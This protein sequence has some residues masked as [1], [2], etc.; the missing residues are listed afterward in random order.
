MAERGPSA[1]YTNPEKPLLEKRMGAFRFYLW[2]E[3]RVCALVSTDDLIT[4]DKGMM[5]SLGTRA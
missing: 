1:R 5:A 2:R 4:D 3:V